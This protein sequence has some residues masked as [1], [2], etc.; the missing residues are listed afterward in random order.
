MDHSPIKR[1]SLQQMKAALHE[2]DEHEL[3]VFLTQNAGVVKQV[4]PKM[5]WGLI[6]HPFII[7]EMRVMICKKGRSRPVV[8]LL[9]MELHENELVFIDKHSTVMIDEYSQD[10]EAEGVTMTD[11]L[12]RLAMGTTIPPSLDGHLRM[13]KLSLTDDEMAYICRLVDLLYDTIRRD[14]C[15]SRVFLGLAATFWWYV[16]QL[17]RSHK[18][19]NHLKS[20][21]E[22]EVFAR[23]ISLVNEHARQQ[24]NLAYYADR[25][26]LSPRYMGSMVK[27]VSGRSAKEWIDEALV[28]AIKVDL[29]H[30]TKPLKQIADEMAFPNTSFFSKFF[31]RMTN[32]T[33]LEYRKRG[34]TI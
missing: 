2:F 3:H 7:E 20:D 23:F 14:D 13:F 31:K 17:Y 33:P 32:L 5:V 6:S 12:F 15:S 27:Q 25:L 11:E 21:R 8:N 9:P 24:H 19:A 18:Q 28:T 1:L 29:R 22:Q 34:T 30:T 26:C 4:A 16:D 10:I